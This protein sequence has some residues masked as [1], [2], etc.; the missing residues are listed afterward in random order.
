VSL[1]MPVLLALDRLPGWGRPAG[2]APGRSGLVVYPISAVIIGLASYWFL[3]RTVL[4]A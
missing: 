2:P 1:V 4:A 3:A